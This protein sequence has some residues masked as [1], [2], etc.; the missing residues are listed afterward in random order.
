M[1][2]YDKAIKCLDDDGKGEF[3]REI[4]S[5]YHGEWLQ[6]CRQRAVVERDVYCLKFIFLV[7][8]GRMLRM[9]KS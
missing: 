8:K 6:L 5:L 7:T 9:M 1:E 2:F 3:C 4:R